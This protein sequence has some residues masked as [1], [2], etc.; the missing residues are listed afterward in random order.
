MNLLGALRR[1]GDRLG[2]IELSH[3][4]QQPSVPVKVETRTITLAELIMTIQIAE[5]RELAELPAELSVSFEDVFKAAGIET[6]PTGWTVDRLLEFVNSD[7]IRKMDHVDAQR[8]TLSMLAAEKVDTA[9][10]VKDAISRDQALDAFE[11]SISKKRQQWQTEKNQLLAELKEQQQQLEQ[12]INDEAKKWKQWR[13]MK[14]QRELDMAR[15]VGYLI[16]KPVISIED[17]Q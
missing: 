11:E 13:R 10:V 9:A 2:I 6:P 12:E 8:E 3:D 15:A 16:D 1:L 17:E 4:P 14:R 7:R 5:V